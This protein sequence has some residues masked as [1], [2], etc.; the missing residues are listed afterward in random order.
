MHYDLIIWQLTSVDKLG[1]L[2]DNLG[3]ISQAFLERLILKIHSLH[4]FHYR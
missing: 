1:I 4:A 3:D 2:A